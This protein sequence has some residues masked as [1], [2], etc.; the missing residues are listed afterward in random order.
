[1]A[2]SVERVGVPR[3]IRRFAPGD[4]GGGPTVARLFEPE[5]AARATMVEGDVDAVAARLVEVF[6]QLG[7]L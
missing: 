2:E 6:R 4:A 5:A 3:C 7:V 1:M